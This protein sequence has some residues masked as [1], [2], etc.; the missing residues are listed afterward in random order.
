M[1]VIQSPSPNFDKRDPAVPLQFIILHYTDMPSGAA[2]LELLQN[3]T[4]K[5]SAHYMLEEDGGIF[6][7]V[8]ENKRAWH[9]GQSFWRGVTDINSA[10]IGI[11]IVN[12]GHRNGY[13]AF[14]TIQVTVLKRLLKEIIARHNLSRNASR[15]LAIPILRRCVSKILVSF[16]LGVTWHKKASGCGRSRVPKITAKPMTARFRNCCATS[17]TI[18]RI[19]APMI[20]QRV[21][22]CWP[23]N[24]VMSRKI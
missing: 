2:A 10:S 20:A 14:T 13:R 21:R 11:E 12:P 3:P 18:A 7:L 24:D 19:T 6:Q 17:V 9:A 16:F 22:P 4:A 5:V 1:T 15:R 23:F 8:D